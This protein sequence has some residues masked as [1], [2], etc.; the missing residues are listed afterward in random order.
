MDIEG[1]AEASTSTKSPSR[2]KKGHMAIIYSTDSD[3]EAIINFVK[4]HEKLYHKT[5]KHFNDKVRKYCLWERFVNSRN[6]S[7]KVCKTWL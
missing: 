6:V 2:N 4:D 7:V 3:E 1:G 5:N